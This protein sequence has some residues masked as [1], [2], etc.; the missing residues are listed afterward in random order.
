MKNKIEK[1]T[2]LILDNLLNKNTMVDCLID[3]THFSCVI[4]IEG[5]KRIIHRISGLITDKGIYLRSG[6]THLDYRRQGIAQSVR[7]SIH[8]V[9]KNEFNQVLYTNSKEFIDPSK[10]PNNISPLFE[11]WEKLVSEGKA[12]KE[13][14]EYRMI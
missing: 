2:K 10:T 4:K 3:R 13:G 9:L 12:E 7:E 1:S 5:N 6:F 14:D 8:S 11:L